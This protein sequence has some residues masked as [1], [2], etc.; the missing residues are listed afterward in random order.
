MTDHQGC[1]RAQQ[2]QGDSQDNSQGD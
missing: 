2:R 1:N